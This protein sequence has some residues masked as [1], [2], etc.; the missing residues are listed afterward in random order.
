MFVCVFATRG[1]SCGIQRFYSSGL[2]HDLRPKIPE[3][4]KYGHAPAAK[5]LPA[6]RVKIIITCLHV[7]LLKIGV[8]LSML[9]GSRISGGAARQS[10]E[11]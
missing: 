4:G 6:A 11:A 8:F 9:S 10:L 5:L 3:H 7:P 2:P 1:V